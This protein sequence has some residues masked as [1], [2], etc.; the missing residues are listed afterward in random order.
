[1]TTPVLDF[2]GRVVDRREEI[3]ELRAAVEEAGRA[4]GGCA[5]LSGISGVGKSTLMQAFGAEISTRNCVFAYGRYQDGAAA[6]Y[7]ALGA[8][9]G[10][11][12]RSMEATGTAERDRWRADLVREMSALT[13]ILEALVPDLAQVLGA[14]PQVA[15]LDAADARR[16]LQRAV[17]RLV[18]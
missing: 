14:E 5:L 18:S 7:S 15:D 17:I 9:L 6:P 2:D 11:I 1:M 8:A 12:V 16:R 3:A 4:G 13:G 10:S